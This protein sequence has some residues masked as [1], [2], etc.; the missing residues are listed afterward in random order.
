MIMR[1]LV[2]NIYQH[3]KETLNSEYK[4]NIYISI[5]LEWNEDKEPDWV[6]LEREICYLESVSSNQ[7]H[8]TLPKTS[9]K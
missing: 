4:F 8:L 2:P 6:I 3:Q 7:M 1:Y 9:V 5:D